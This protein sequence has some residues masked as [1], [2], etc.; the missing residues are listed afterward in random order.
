MPDVLSA[1]IQKRLSKK[2]SHLGKIPQTLLREILCR[3][4]PRRMPRQIDEL[5]IDNVLR[6]A[7]AY[8]KA[9]GWKGLSQV[10]REAHGDWRTFERLAQGE[11]SLTLRKYVEIR[12]WFENHR[13]TFRWPRLY[14]PWAEGRPRN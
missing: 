7:K 4:Y 2:N 5:L 6:L 8:S 12:Q 10:S 9:K 13:G 1:A 14:E 3:V 11:G